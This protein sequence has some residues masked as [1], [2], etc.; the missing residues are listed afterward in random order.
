MLKITSLDNQKIKEIIS[1]TK[2]KKRRETGVII[3]DGYREIVAAWQ[4]KLEI[5][6]LFYCQELDNIGLEIFSSLNS[7]RIIEVN[8][9]VFRKICY[10]ENPD[11]FFALIRKPESNLNRLKLSKKP[12]IIILESVEKPGNLGAIIR[13]A[14]AAG[15][16]AIIIND[17]KTD[18]YNPNV[19]RASEGLIF[20]QPIFN[21]SLK[22]TIKFLKENKIQS[23]AAGTKGVLNYLE[24]DYNQACAIVLGSEDKGL[25]KD[26]F[27]G[28]DKIIKINMKKGVDSLN[29]SVSTSI[30][31]FEALRQRKL[32]L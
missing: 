15:V 31:V 20:F 29:V 30:I 7:E 12:L 10:K 21:L 11:G 9:R 13:T 2:N 4:A 18:I 5:I 32:N 6:D 22:E 14:C 27:E 17:E 26:W 28:S 8:E 3:V 19:I 25:S 1:L 16:E 24:A 23:L